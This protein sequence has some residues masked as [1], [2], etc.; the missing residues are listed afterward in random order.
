MTRKLTFGLIG[1]ALIALAACGYRGDLDRP[2]PRWGETAEQHRQQQNQEEP[3][4]TADAE[5]PQ[6]P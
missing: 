1:A 3:E 5:A 6:Q 4:D 2:P